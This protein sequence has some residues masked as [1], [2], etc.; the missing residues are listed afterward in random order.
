MNL[1]GRASS[2]CGS[3][4]YLSPEMIAFNM[5]SF[6]IN[7][8]YAQGHGLMV[9]Y[10]SLGVLLYEMHIGM[11]PFY[12]TNQRRM[13]DKIVYSEVKFPFNLSEDFKDILKGLLCKDPSKR[14]GF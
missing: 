5:G 3:P 9:D 13:L 14:L 4:E 7:S 11:P 6:N 12:D 1:H 8:S 10:Y 2:F